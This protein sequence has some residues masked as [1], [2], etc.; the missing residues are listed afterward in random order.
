MASYDAGIRHGAAYEN[1]RRSVIGDL[2]QCRD[3]WGTGTVTWGMDIPADEH[4]VCAS[5]GGSGTVALRA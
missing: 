1:L 4:E 5:C 3:C 2:V